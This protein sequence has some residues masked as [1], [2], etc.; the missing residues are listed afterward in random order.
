MVMI[1]KNIDF[2][3]RRE[4]LTN[5]KKR[6]AM[7]KSGTPRVVVRK[8]NRRIIGQ[9]VTYNEK[10]DV[11]TAYTDSFQVEKKFGWPSRSNRPTAYLTGVM[12]AKSVKDKNGTSYILD[13]GLGS[14]VKNSIP[15]IFA[16]GCI[17]G[18][19]NLQATVDGIDENIYNYSNTTY[20][21]KLKAEDP[22]LYEKQYGKYVKDGKDPE[23][24]H[25][26]FDS[27][28]EKIMKE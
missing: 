21:K 7:I 6:L 10:G 24:L 26:L 5:Y 13:I 17:D 15:F 11:V 18:G 22:K 23:S 9:I 25:T 4:A 20:A 14:H 28:K 16:K 3:R 8:S 2:R 27:V 1:M 12:L 19:M